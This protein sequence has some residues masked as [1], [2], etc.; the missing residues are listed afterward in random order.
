MSDSAKGTYLIPGLRLLDSM[1]ACSNSFLNRCHE[2]LGLLDGV[3]RIEK[4]ASNR[5]VEI[6][7]LMQCDGPNS[8]C[9]RLGKNG[10]D[11]TGL[12]QGI[13]RAHLIHFHADGRPY[14]STFERGIQP[15]TSGTFARSEDEWSSAQLL[16]CD[17]RRKISRGR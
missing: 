17:P 12:D 10:H 9:Q 3:S 8:S 11:G 15:K 1:Q 13:D 14:A 6:T 4:I 2:V 5:D 16:E 7:N